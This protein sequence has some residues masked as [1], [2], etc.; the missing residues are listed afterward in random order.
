[1]N[2]LPFFVASYRIIQ[3]LTNVN[4]RSDCSFIYFVKSVCSIRVVD[5]DLHYI[6]TNPNKFTAL[7][8]LFSTWEQS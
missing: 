2:Q 1:V 3:T 7:N 5:L 8:R 6:I 4:S